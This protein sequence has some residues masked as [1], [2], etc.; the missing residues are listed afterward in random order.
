[1][2]VKPIPEGYQTVMPY[3]IVSGAA[4]AIEFYQQAFGATELT[5]ITGAA[6]IAHAEI[7]IGDARVM[8]ADEFPEMGCRSPQSFGGSPISLMLYVDNVDAL[9]GQALAAGATAVRPIE[10]QFYGHRC[11]TLS[12]P[13]GHIWTISTQVEA[14]APEA[15]QRR[16]DAMQEA[17]V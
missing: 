7:S 4:A 5:R 10:N 11:G 15:L 2:A 16:F 9:F 14:V 3:L 8:L 6:G 12:D 17:I 1:M 13:F